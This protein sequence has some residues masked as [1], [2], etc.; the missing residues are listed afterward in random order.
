MNKYMVKVVNVFSNVIE[1]EAED[2]DGAKKAAEA[3]LVDPN[4][5]EKV[6]HFYESTLPPEHWAVISK[7]KYEELK[8]QVEAGLVPNANSDEPNNI[9]EPK[10]ITP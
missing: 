4:N 5:N 1:V 10:I 3:K 7:D 6:E 9:V 8:S 2:E